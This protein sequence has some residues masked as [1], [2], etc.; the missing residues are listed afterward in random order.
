MSLFLTMRR[1]HCW[2]AIALWLVVLVLPHA[3][4]EETEKKGAEQ[5]DLLLGRL[6]FSPDKR[7]ALD[8]LR[9]GVFSEVNNAPRRAQGEKIITGPRY[10]SVSGIVIKGNGKNVVWLNGQSVTARDRF[11]GEGFRAFPNRMDKRGIPISSVDSIRVFYLK[12]GQTL[13][14]VEGRARNTYEIDAHALVTARREPLPEGEGVAKTEHVTEKKPKEVGVVT[15]PVAEKKAGEKAEEGNVA[16]EKVSKLEKMVK[17]IKMATG[18]AK[19]VDDVFS[20]AAKEGI[21]DVPSLQG[22]NP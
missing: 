8:L 21:T 9:Q 18:M 12:P 2:M 3:H 7:Q 17:T 11:D 5:E 14:F 1:S 15:G 19:M 13:D 10:V 22:K 16:E 4:A 6:F 20:F